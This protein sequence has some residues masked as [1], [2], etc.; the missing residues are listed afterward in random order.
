MSDVTE[1]L[2]A[3]QELTRPTKEIASTFE[4]VTT[5]TKAKGRRVD[6]SDRNEH[7]RLC[8]KEGCDRKA[9]QATGRSDLCQP[10]F[11]QIPRNRKPASSVSS[12]RQKVG[13]EDL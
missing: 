13:E 9:R 3:L 5:K 12:K 11:E 6:W 8:K 4:V 10:C 2:T 1:A 7:W